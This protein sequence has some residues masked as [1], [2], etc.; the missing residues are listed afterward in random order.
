M[1]NIINRLCAILPSNYVRQRTVAPSV[2]VY[3]IIF[4]AS[5]MFHF[6]LAAFGIIP[7]RSRVG[8]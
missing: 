4:R 3:G 6:T 2:C 1:R 8:V 7:D 5:C